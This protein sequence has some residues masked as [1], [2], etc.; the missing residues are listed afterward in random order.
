MNF[1]KNIGMNT[2]SQRTCLKPSIM[3]KFDQIH[4]YGRKYQH[5]GNELLRII[6]GNIQ[7][8]DWRQNYNKA[9]VVCRASREMVCLRYPQLCHLQSIQCTHTLRIGK[10]NNIQFGQ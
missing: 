5:T 2:A 4:K 6:A 10:T 9:Q 3:L 1:R 7:R 8:F